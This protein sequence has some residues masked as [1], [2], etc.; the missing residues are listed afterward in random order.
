MLQL[1]SSDSLEVLLS[2]ALWLGKT[3]CFI[4]F[5][6]MFNLCGI[7][8][9]KVVRT[10][11]ISQKLSYSCRMSLVAYALQ[12]IVFN[13]TAEP[14][15]LS[16]GPSHQCAQHPF[17]HPHRSTVLKETSFAVSFLTFFPP[18][19]LMKKY[20][21]SFASLFYVSMENVFFL[22][23]WANQNC[24]T[25][26]STKIEHNFNLTC[27]LNLGLKQHFFLSEKI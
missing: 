11:K 19:S 9:N 21:Y 13:R 18:L 3:V 16:P 8:C 1:A 12:H 17:L 5:Y 23:F 27:L 14:T 20:F 22:S 2:L 7:F 26:N 25:K 15:M 6:W 24:K 10:V 4:F